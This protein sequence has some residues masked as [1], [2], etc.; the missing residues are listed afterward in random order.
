M[1]YWQT[2]E[3]AQ[4]LQVGYAPGPILFT[5]RDIDYWAKVRPALLTSSVVVGM[6]TVV[7]CVWVYLLQLELRWA[8]YRHISGSVEML[9]RYLAYQVRLSDP[10]ILSGYLMANWMYRFC[11]F[12]YAWS[13]IF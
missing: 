2:M 6:C 5:N 7:A 8:I 12:W 9:K 10:L 11:W 4:G 1:R 13:R 3:T